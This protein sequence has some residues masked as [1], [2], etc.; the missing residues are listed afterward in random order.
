MQQIWES[1]AIALRALWGSKLRSALTIL[2]VVISITSIIAVVSIVDG[3]DYYVKTEIAEQ[4]SN[5][6]TVSRVNQWEILTDF[7]KFLKSLK[8]PKLTLEDL[9]ALRREMTLAEFTDAAMD[10]NERLNNGRRFVEQV[11]IRGRTEE[12]AAIGD[13]PLA[14]GRHLSPIDIQQRREVCVVG[15]EIANSLFPNSDPI[16]QTVKIAGR[17][18]TIVGVCEKKPSVLGSNQ[19]IFAYIPITTH[20][21]HFGSRWR[22]LE[23]PIRTASM[24]TFQAAQEEARQILRIRHKLKP[25]EE[26]DFYITASEQLLSIW[27][28]ISKGIFGSLIGVVGITLVVGG[29]IIMNVMLVAVTERTREIGVRKALGAK[30]RNITMQFVIESITLTL[31]G[32]VIGIVLGF[33]FAYL[34]A[35]FSPLPYR[36]APWSIIVALFISFIVGLTFGVY[37]ARK[38][39]KLD[40]VVAL[41]HE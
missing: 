2:C 38:A 7:D 32:G 17:H 5:V 30:R 40:P 8:N 19:N 15:S 29:I 13:F 4:G 23:F 21:K 1:L 41:R 12:Y 18:Y 16:Q 35:A 26:D 33:F 39:A 14:A 36:I 27:E 11:E 20:L 25:A 6:F 9:E 31:V 3:M 22:S 34:V 28:A 37:P 10:R 24:E